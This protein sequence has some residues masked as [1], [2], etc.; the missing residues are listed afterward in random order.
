MTIKRF[1][2]DFGLWFA[3][4]VLVLYHFKLAFYFVCWWKMLQPFLILQCVY[5][6]QYVGPKTFMMETSPIYF[7]YLFRPEIFSASP[8]LKHKLDI[9]KRGEGG[10]DIINPPLVIFVTHF[11]YLGHH[12]T[13]PFEKGCNQRKYLWE[14]YF[15]PGC[16]ILWYFFNLND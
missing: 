15:L 16:N 9:F 12:P 11:L 7:L 8:K 5:F 13:Y 14:D 1:H 3:I 10:G 6:C 4:D 2:T